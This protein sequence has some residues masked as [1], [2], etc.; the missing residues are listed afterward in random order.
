[1]LLRYRANSPESQTD[2]AYL[3]LLFLT[4]SFGAFKRECATFCLIYFHHVKLRNVQSVRVK[5]SWASIPARAR[6]WKLYYRNIKTSYLHRWIVSVQNFLIVTLYTYPKFFHRHMPKIFAPRISSES[7]KAPKN[8]SVNI[9]LK[10]KL[11]SVLFGTVKSAFYLSRVNFWTINI[12]RKCSKTFNFCRTL[13]IFWWL[14]P[15]FFTCPEERF[16]HKV[17]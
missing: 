14:L 17:F 7:D 5:I 11:L 12:V 4:L 10:Q 15:N 13:K 2:H 16:K 8:H 9:F 3:S 1:M 6:I